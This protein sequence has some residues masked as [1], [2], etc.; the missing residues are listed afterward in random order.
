MKEYLSTSDFDY[1]LPEEMIAQHPP[2]ERG[3]SRMLVMNRRTGECEIRRF[4]DI[5]DYLSPGDAM[6]VNNTK[7]MNARFYGIKENG[8]A[9][10]ELLLTMPLN[11][12]AVKW[13]ALIK[14]GKRV[15]AG[16]KI[17]L[18]PNSF[19][20]PQTSDSNSE[21]SVTVL[22]KN[23]DGSFNIEFQSQNSCDSIEDATPLEG[24]GSLEEHL[25]DIEYIQEFYGHT[26]L[27]PYIRRSDSQDDKQRYQTVYARESGAVAA[28][29]AGLH[30]T[31]EI[32]AKCADMGVESVEVTLHVGPGTF[33]PVTVEDPR[34]HQMHSETFTLTK[35]SADLL[36]GVHARG[37]KI[38]AVGTTSVRVLETC[39]DADGK[40]IP[41][42]GIT[43]IF[44]YPPMKPKVADMLLTNF[45]LPKSTLLMLVATFAEK[46]HVM[47]AYEVAKNAGFKFYSYGDC[48]L[49]V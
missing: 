12:E 25:C 29:T 17:V 6:V 30:F 22:N 5:T 7:V 42:S 15:R 23:D 1:E 16:T 49:L 28:P 14:P 2:E 10:I 11:R 40:L 39:S 45:H 36:N 13:K 9:K 34:D 27:P 33:Q 20:D 8:G 18:T 21:P 26:P 46:E 43:D 35:E 3:S 24:R 48:M 31:D 47:N 44:L 32:Y 41:G 19:H 4:S 37:K 38:L